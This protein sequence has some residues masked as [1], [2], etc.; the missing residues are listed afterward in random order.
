MTMKRAVAESIVWAALGKI[1]DKELTRE[2]IPPGEHRVQG[3]VHG[4]VG[5]LTLEISA[6]ATLAVGEDV[7]QLRSATPDQPK[8]VA[9]LLSYLPERTRGTVLRDLAE[10]YAEDEVDDV[11]KAQ[12][13]T[14]LEKLRTKESILKRGA[15]SCRYDL[16]R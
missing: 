11:L 15:V 2:L 5:G 16:T 14:L 8:L 12:A 4:Q 7:Q 6:A 1:A 9:L 3:A 10:K 13:K